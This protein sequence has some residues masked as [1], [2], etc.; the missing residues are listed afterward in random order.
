VSGLL[1]RTRSGNTVTVEMPR[2]GKVYY[3]HGTTHNE[4]VSDMWK[5][6]NCDEAGQPFAGSC[7]KCG[8]DRNKCCC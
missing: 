3:G 1:K 8:A 5:S 7:L 4:A 2:N 6:I